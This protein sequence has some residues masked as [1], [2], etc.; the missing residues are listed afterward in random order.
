MS[1]SKSV[2][3]LSGGWPGH[4]PEKTSARF[5]KL[6]EAEGCLVEIS[7]SLDSAADAERLI[8]QFDLV[9]PNWTMGELSG[10][11]Q[12]GL[13]GAVAAGVGVAGIHG[14]AGDAFRAACEF[15]FMMGGQFVAHPGNIKDYTVFIADH[16]HPI[17]QGLEPSFAYKS[18]QYYMHVD[19]AVRVL[20]TTLVNQ[21]TSENCEGVLMPVAWTKKHGK[22]RV[23][24]NALGHQDAEF[25][26]FPQA[27]QFVL[28]GMLWA[29]R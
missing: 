19:P 17:T 16:T 13:C 29:M 28:N 12:K 5:A 25:D 15:Q 14:G 26:Q 6:L 18:E 24:Y 7:H 22:G 20:A 3:I 1:Q 2:L 10:E 23:Y 9:I 27:Q 8:Q 21:P 4:E 11:Q